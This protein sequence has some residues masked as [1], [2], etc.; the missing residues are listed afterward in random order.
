MLVPLM[1]GVALAEAI[2]AASGLRVDLKWPN[3]LFV[4]RRKVGGILAEGVGA[5]D[6]AERGVPRGLAKVVLGYGINVGAAA[7]PPDISDRATSVETEL[8]RTVDRAQLL[9]ETVAALSDR[10]G[11]LLAGRYDAILDAWRARAPASRGAAVRWSTPDGE[12]AGV[13]AGI[14]GD[15]ALLVETAS[16]LERIVAGELRWL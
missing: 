6:E 11:D 1:A 4:G 5:D 2:G 13:T 15:G 14:D 7:F 16:S 3:D 12:R 8:G 9:A 10:Y